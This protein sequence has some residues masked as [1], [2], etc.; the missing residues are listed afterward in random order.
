MAASSIES[1]TELFARLGRDHVLAALRQLD[2]GATTRFADSRKF[3][4]LYRGKRYAP[5]EVGGLA[6]EALTGRTFG[7]RDFKGGEESPCFRALA[8]CGFTVVLKRTSEAA[9]P[10]AEVLSEILHL[11]QRY[12]SRNTPDMQRRGTLIRD[13]LPDIVRDH[14]ESIEPYFSRA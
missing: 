4:V 2:A 7:P 1:T 13:A 8:R 12:S 10:L 6:L 5:K 14:L 9:T 3:D 11:Q